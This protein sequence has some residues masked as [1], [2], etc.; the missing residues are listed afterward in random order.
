MQLFT[1]IQLISFWFHEI[2]IGRQQ[3]PSRESYVPRDVARYRG[4]IQI[5]HCSKLALCVSNVPCCSKNSVTVLEL[6]LSAYAS[7]KSRASNL[8]SPLLTRGSK[9]F[10]ATNDCA[11]RRKHSCHEIRDGLLNVTSTQPP[12]SSWSVMMEANVKPVEKASFYPQ[13]TQHQR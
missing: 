1:P 11:E 12:L 6:K 13:K 5:M 9:R 8:P 2:F 3:V 4:G 10:A 7:L